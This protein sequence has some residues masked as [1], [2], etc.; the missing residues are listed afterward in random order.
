MVEL[1]N[2]F[3]DEPWNCHKGGHPYLSDSDLDEVVNELQSDP[4]K[5]ITHECLTDIHH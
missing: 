5:V 4:G 2:T 1:G 3:E